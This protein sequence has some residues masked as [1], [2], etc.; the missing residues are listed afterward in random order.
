MSISHEVSPLIRPRSK[1]LIRFG[2]ELN[3]GDFVFRRAT[4]LLATLVIAVLAAMTIAMVYGSAESLKAFGLDFI[5][6][7]V[8]DPVHGV[9]GALPFIYG[10]IASS[11][12]ALCFAVP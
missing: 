1:I 4:A 2:S 10:T 7:Q 9:F 8:W 12:L 3:W 11:L 6:S 5:G